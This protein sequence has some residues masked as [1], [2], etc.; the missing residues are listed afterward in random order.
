MA[1]HGGDVDSEDSS[2]EYKAPPKKTLQELQQLD[3]ED[4][5]L[6]R[7]KEAL[8]GALDLKADVP[9]P[10][11]PKCVVFESFT[12]CVEGQPDRTISLLDESSLDNP[13]CNRIPIPEGT[14][15]HIEV[16][17]YVQ[18]DIVTGLQYE[19]SVHRGP[20]RVDHST[21]M[22]GSYAPQRDVR[23]WKSEML[24]APK[25]VVHRGTYSIKSRFRDVD[26]TEYIS[27]KWSIDVCK[28]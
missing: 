19:Q 21:V 20:L 5:S 27:W 11:N 6:K 16:R 25:G 1:D 4:E 24:E 12:V 8:L 18:R 2:V 22:L 9:F 28:P 13:D 15:Y 17:Y 14:S 26:K 7:Y 10:N 3:Q 23:V